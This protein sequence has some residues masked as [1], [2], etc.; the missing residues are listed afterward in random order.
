MA[1]GIH[2]YSNM[3]PLRHMIHFLENIAKFIK[4][5]ICLLY[6]TDIAYFLSS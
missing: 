1:S 3:R 2:C 4:R 6:L 5:I